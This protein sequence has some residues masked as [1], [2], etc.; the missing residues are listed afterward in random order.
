M[1]PVNNKTISMLMKTNRYPVAAPVKGM[2]L[3]LVLV[4]FAGMN[5]FAQTY[6]KNYQDGRLYFKFKDNVNPGI[7]VRSD[8]SVDLNQIPFISQLQSQFRL[9]SLSRPFYLNDDPKLL[10]TFMLEIEDYPK[11][12]EVINE[13]LNEQDLEYVEKVPMEYIHYV[14]NDSLYNLYTGPNN[15]NWH[16]DVI[17]AEQAWDISKGSADIK[18][19]VV[20]NAVWVNHPDLADKIVAQ[21]DTYYNTNDANPPGTGDPFDWSHGTHCAGL[22]GAITDNGT[23]IA[24][25]GYNVSLIAVKAANNT[26]ANG[27]Y[28]FPGIQWAA[29]NGADVISMS[30][31]G[32]GYSATNQNLINTIYNMGIV[33]LASAGNDNVSTAHYP[34]GY[35]NVISIASTNS[36]DLKTDFSNFGTTV[37]LC[38]PGGYATPGPS[39]LLSTTYN[40]STYGNYDLMAGTSM[41]TPVAAGLAGLIL[42]IN[43]ALTPAQVETI[44]KTTADDVYAVN[45]TYTGQLGSGR[46]NAYRAAANTPFEPTAG[47]TTPVTTILPGGGVDFTDIST[48][49]P[50]T[51]QWS[52]QGGTPNSSTQQHPANIRYNSPGVYDVTLTVTNVFGTSTLV[53]EDYITATN[54]PAPYIYVNVSDENPCIYDDVTLMDESLYSPNAWE[55]IITPET[56]EY[57]NGTSASSQ[58]P[59]VNFLVPGLYSVALNA[60]N[61][62]GTSSVNL[63]NYIDV[64]GGHPTFTV[65]MEDGTS[66]AFMVWDTVKSQSKIDSRAANMSAF[67]IHFHGDPIPTGWSGGATSTTPAQAWGTNLAFHGKAYICGVDATGMDNVAL[68]LD[69]RQTFSLGS[70][71]SWFRVTVNGEP[72]AD[73]S[74]QTDF[75]PGTAA[76]DEWKTLTFDLSAYA[77]TV[78]DVVLQTATRFSDKTQGEGDN[79]FIDNISI[80]NTT[81]VRPQVSTARELKVY[82]NPSS[83]LFTISTGILNGKNIGIR[84]SSLPGNL[85]YSE[86]VVAG[87]GAFSKAI[88]LSHLPSGV[89]LLMVSDGVQQLNQ[90]LIIR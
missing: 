36:D 62:N 7:T 71:F 15:W 34:S 64:Q 52:F 31:G 4:L 48:G 45:P 89:Y 77:G 54:T 14:P 2:L 46:I 86:N 55:W 67:G 20:D 10:R 1:L 3:L 39:G 72:V 79:V 56:V 44:M 13:L 37:D 33:L 17:Q 5:L 60:S 65:D 43:P 82:P 42:S 49:V 59:Q 18:V 32:P 50:S 74:G 75:N 23:G 11:I 63:E 78:F 81:P 88:D 51:W 90:R 83:G 6:D 27:I 38:A 47:F 22:V 57:I 16:L 25:I 9:K 68:T 87:S 21:R 26:N 85:V 61:N 70:K 53:L 30:W 69:L 28:G 40:S 12:A 8:N 24:S 80:T 29:N 84:V 73:E 41:A 76:A 35:N 58:N 19:A 66:G